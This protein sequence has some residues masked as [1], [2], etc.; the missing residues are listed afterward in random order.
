M[1]RIPVW[2]CSGFGKLTFAQS[3][4]S[5]TGL[6]SISPDAVFW[7]PDWVESFWAE[8]CARMRSLLIQEHWFLY[9]NDTT[10]LQGAQVAWATRVFCFDPPRWRCLKSAFAQIAHGGLR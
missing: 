3:L 6:S 8:F 4:S 10:A 1:P 9:G 7:L 5:E 2:G